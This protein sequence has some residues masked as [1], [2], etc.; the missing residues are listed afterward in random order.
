MAIDGPAT[1]EES[2]ARAGRTAPPARDASLL[3][4]VSDAFL[5][6]DASW[7]VTYANREAA[8]LNGLTPEA[9]LGRSHWDIWPETIGTEVERIYRRVVAERTPAHFEHFYPLSGVWHEVSAYPAD[10]GGLSI[11][12]RDVTDRRRA[13]RAARLLSDVAVLLASA[14]DERAQ[15]EALAR[16]LVPTLADW[17]VID[18][19]DEAGTVR[20]AAYAHGDPA[21]A[22]TLRELAERF[23]PLAHR[24]TL[25]RDTVASMTSTLRK[26][27]PDASIDEMTRDPEQAHLV[28]A[29]G[30]RSSIVV[31]MLLRGRL[32]GVIAL[33]SS[34][35]RFDDT[36]VGLAEEL[37]RRAA[38][39][40]EIARASAAALAARAAA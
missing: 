28:R 31:P 40:M 35:R 14:A 4:A 32:L 18:V 38:L 6:L 29:L 5:A 1:D 3:D 39:A 23:P 10:G 11:F 30:M 26:D 36:D 9:L 17:C 33:V 37:A 24:P 34:S 19:V 20:R 8:R 16:A 22:A 13:D 2:E 27:V 25:A 12:Y 7:R 15:H 21:M